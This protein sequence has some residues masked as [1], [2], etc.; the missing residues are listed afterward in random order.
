MSGHQSQPPVAPSSREQSE[1]AQ[2]L[3]VVSNNQPRDLLSFW[4][5]SEKDQRTIR[6]EFDWM[7]D[8]EDDSMF[9]KYRGHIYNAG[10]FLRDGTPDGWDGNAPDSYFSGV[11]VKLTDD[12]EAVICGR[13]SV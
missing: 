12:C 3:R 11:L 6:K 9:F 4:D 8:L 10:E 7:E 13:W 1:A 2:Q 5:F